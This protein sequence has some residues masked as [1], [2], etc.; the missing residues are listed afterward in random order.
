MLIVVLRPGTTLSVQ[1]TDTEHFYFALQQSRNDFPNRAHV[2]LG[3]MTVSE[4]SE[5]ITRAQVLKENASAHVVIVTHI[6]RMASKAA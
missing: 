1:K 5:I 6:N 4:L 3:E 2:A